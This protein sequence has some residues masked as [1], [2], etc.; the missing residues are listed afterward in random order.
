VRVRGVPVGALAEAAA[1]LV[2]PG[3]LWPHRRLAAL[4]RPATGRATLT[5][6]ERRLV[7]GVDAAL[8]RLGVRCLRRAVILT[9]M[10]RQRGVAARVQISV[11]RE[12]PREA[13]AEVE[14]GGVP[15]RATA[16]GWVM[17]R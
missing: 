16:P 6:D 17:L 13:H 11:A 12:S 3:I 9:D 15:V 8:R 14:I 2:T 10:L 7:A 4:V 1:R 5:L